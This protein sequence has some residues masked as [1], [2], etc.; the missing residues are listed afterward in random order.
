MK[1]IEKE[2]K[3]DYNIRNVQPQERRKRAE[4]GTAVRRSR[5][6]RRHPGWNR[7]TTYDKGDLMKRD[8]ETYWYKDIREIGTIKELLD[9]SAGLYAENPAFWVKRKKGA[10]YEAVSYRL[11]KHDV[12]SLGTKLVD[13]G[14]RGERIAVMGQGCYE[15]IVSYLAVVN[16]T[17]IAVPI[18]KDLTP[19][20]IG[21]LLSAA[22]CHTIFCTAA[23]S[24]KLKD[25]PGIERKVVMEIYG[26]RTSEEEAPSTGL[27]PKDGSAVW[28]NL[29]AEGEMLLKEGDIRFTKAEIDPEALS[30][31]L[32]TSGTTGNPK[33]VMLNHRNIT[34]NIMDVCRIAHILESDKTLSILPIH[35]TYECTLGMLLVLYRGASTAFCEGLRYIVQNMKEAHNTVLIAVP[36]VLE[37]IYSKIWK[38]VAKQGKE[39]TLK[40]AIR[41]NNRLKSIGIDM[42][43][44]LFSQI[45][46]ELGGSL[47]MIITGAAAL[48]P[49]VYR[50]FEDLGIIVLQGYGMTECTPLISGTPQSS[51]ERYKKAG[52]VGV[53]VRAG[54]VKIIGQDENGIG[55]ILFRGPNV[56]MGYYN[57]PEETAEVLDSDG[58]LHTGDLGFEDKDGWIYLTGRKK[59]IIVT[60]T[61]KNIY[62]E[63][64]EIQANASP[65]IADSMVFTSLRNGEETVGI[66]ILPDLEYIKE[67]LGEVPEESDLYRL[68]KKVIGELNESLP[69][70][71]RIRDVFVRKEDFTRTTTKKIRRQDNTE[72]K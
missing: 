64:L 22:D 61:G 46:R 51:G 3:S 47:R 69:N 70:Y 49:N 38:S 17:G 23:E 52:S 21:N 32:F 42:S 54:E 25:I 66:Q 41:I 40:R 2:R 4:N 44:R 24:G 14:L 26:D 35:H 43:R 37:M 67:Q 39:K 31:I 19:S 9:G 11:L 5:S 30:V 10:P 53:P 12:D 57:M 58:W 15:W 18:D 28:R 56:M 71:K 33:G 34:S 72:V 29:L 50:G 48:S 55:E 7:T 62:P 13:M 6:V 16:G 36:L 68:M 1:K 45:H 27:V 60:K 63:E 65:Y 59:N 20:E 8:F